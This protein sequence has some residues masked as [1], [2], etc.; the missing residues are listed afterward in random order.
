MEIAIYGKKFN[1]D[2]DECIIR[3]FEILGKAKTKVYIYEPF[4][5]FINKR[6]PLKSEGISLFTDK[7]GIN[8]NCDILLSI[9][10]DGTFLESVVFVKNKGIPIAGINSGRLGFLANISKNEMEDALDRILNKSYSFEKRELIQLE[11]PDNEFGNNNFAL[12]EITVQKTD[13]SSM[14]TIHVYI[15]GYFLNT[16]W[17]DGLIIATPT[18][19]HELT[20]KIEG[21]DQNYLVSLDHRHKVFST[22]VEL[23]I[24]KSKFKIKMLKHDDKSFYN[25]LREK[26]MWGLDK[27]N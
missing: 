27:R 20:L 13:S 6:V 3:L 15:D 4:F 21:R 26:L 25:T 11:T 12:N 7:K 14:I 16:Y 5:N 9:G 17:A 24:K 2:F 22:S 1:P 10:G 18:N 19:H 23:K 8:T